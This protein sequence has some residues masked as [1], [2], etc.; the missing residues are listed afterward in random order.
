[1][2]RIDQYLTKRSKSAVV[3]CRKRTGMKK[4]R[5]SKHTSVSIYKVGHEAVKQYPSAGQRELR[6]ILMKEKGM[7]V[8]RYAL[9]R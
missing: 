8:S 6:N 1:M 5:S 7:F 4:S 3:E 2:N 9:H